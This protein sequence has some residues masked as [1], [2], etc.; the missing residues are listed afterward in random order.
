MDVTELKKMRRNL[1]RFLQRFAPCIKTRPSQKHLQT[2]VHG[3]IS[4]LARKSVEPIALDAGVP[5]R[6]LQKFLAEHRWNE[7][8]V[9]KKIRQIVRRD[10]RDEN[11]IGIIDETSFP[12]KGD[13]T[14]CV[15]PQYC[16]ATGKTDNC[17][18]SVD[19]A[20]AAGDFHTLVD[21]DLYL[22]EETWHENRTRCRA[23]GIPD[24][25]VYRPKWQIAL[26]IIKRSL[27]DGIT[28][29]Y[30]TADELYGGTAA[31]RHGVA[32]L[33]LTY[34]VEIPRDVPGW[35]E[36][37]LKKGKVACR[38][39]EL[40][41]RGGPRWQMFHLKDSEKGPLVWEV[42][43]A[44]FSVREVGIPTAAQWLIVARNVLTGEVKYFLANAS[45]EVSMET[46]LH[47]AFSRWRVERLFED[48]KGQV[49]LADFE[50]RNYLPLMRHLILSMVSVLF[51]MKESARVGEKKHLVECP[52]NPFG[53]RG[54]A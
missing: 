54:A 38:V 9:A 52:A 26:D 18:V 22:P 21:S 53:C 36:G 45:A 3:Q 27:D 8:A 5:P 44:R 7:V 2:Y 33:G 46:L 32:T 37:R 16:G 34:V 20:Y 12:K 6:T 43:V 29:K 28:M 35:T 48:A 49:G 50:V 15:Q 4:R 25:V 11:A 10:H 31:F 30:L 17:V 39:D 1:T 51:L 14:A 19:L 47:V 41:R 13:K 42:R 24:H 23:A 40:W